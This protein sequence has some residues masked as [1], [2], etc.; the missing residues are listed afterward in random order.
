MISG[1]HALTYSK[2][3]EADRAFIG[4]VSSLPPA[5]AGVIRSL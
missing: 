3:A 1:A 5:A 2:D 4:D